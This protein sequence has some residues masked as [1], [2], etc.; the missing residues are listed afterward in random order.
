MFDFMP[1]IGIGTVAPMIRRMRRFAP[2]AGLKQAVAGE[3]LPLPELSPGIHELN[4][5]LTNMKMV[6]NQDT[7]RR[8]STFSNYWSMKSDYSR[9]NS[10]VCVTP[11]FFCYLFYNTLFFY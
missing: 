3:L 10:Q 4:K 1:D 7:M 9:R 11:D 5:Q 2:H 8:E 6:S